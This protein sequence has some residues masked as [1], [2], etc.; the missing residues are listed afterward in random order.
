MRITIK[1]GVLASILFSLLFAAMTDSVS[2]Q[3][4][5]KITHRVRFARGQNSAALKGKIKKNQEIIYTVRASKGQTLTARVTAS[6]PNHD[7]VF[8]IEGPGNKALM[9]EGDLNTE[10][11]GQLPESGDYQISLGMIESESSDYTLEVSVR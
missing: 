11:T 9:E 2:A 1:A 8:T 3:G 7:V 4:G 5:G 6:T 10:W